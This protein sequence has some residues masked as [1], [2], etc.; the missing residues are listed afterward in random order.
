MIA[1]AKSPILEPLDGRLREPQFYEELG[2]RSGLEIHQQLLTEKKLF[3]HCPAG[4]YV[5]DHDAVILRHMRPTL[6]ELGEYDGTALMEFKTRKDI[7]YLLNRRNVCT[8]EM[9]DTPPFMIN[10]QALDIAIEIAQLLGCQIVGEIHVSRKQYLDGSIPTGFQRTAIVGVSGAIPFRGREVGIIQ[11]AVE[12]DS[13]REVSDEGHRIIFRTDRLSM[14]L[15]ETV[16]EPEM[17]TP[18]EVAAVCTA[19][20]R[21]VRVTGKV[22]RGIGSVREDVNVSIDGGTRVEIK[23]VCRIPYIPALVHNEALRQRRL[24]GLGEHLRGLG[25]DRESLDGGAFEAAGLLESSRAPL[26]QRAGAA[27]HQARVQVIRGAREA[28]RAWTQPGLCFAQELSGRVRVIACLDQEVNLFIRDEEHGFGL[29]RHAWAPR[30]ELLGPS[31]EEWEGLARQVGASEQDGLALVFGPEQDVQTAT[32]EVRD[33]MFEA[34]EGVPSETRMPF[35]SGTT[36]FERILPGPDRMYPDTDL[37]PVAIA[38]ERV[39]RIGAALPEAPWLREAR[40]RERGAAEQQAWAAVISPYFG[41]LAEI[42]DA[43]VEPA[44]VS[45]MTWIVAELLKALRRRGVPVDALGE[46]DLREVLGAVAGGRL[47]R[48][49]A[50]SVVERLARRRASGEHTGDSAEAAL[51]ASLAEAL[52]DA[53]DG[54]RPDAAPEGLARLLEP[55]REIRFG[56]EAARLRALMGVVMPSL[57]GRVEGRRIHDAVAGWLEADATRAPADAPHRPRG[58]A[59]P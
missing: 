37:P 8:Y 59:R 11:L 3:C 23:G 48:E 56:G 42:A 15:V 16:T 45:T 43:G 19:L 57:R 2:F 54:A 50:A 30:E 26:L 40:L 41:L 24:V 52:P 9:D 46:A 49:T 10:E 34:L 21:L 36:D 44:R 27:G 17:R 18:E 28:L 12:E 47:L 38:D 32:N 53:P 5:T 51:A 20:G 33:R 39:E 14:P 25:L 1:A 6:S 22:R 13:C 7:V 29:C 55:Q 31:A 4:I 35:P 58:G